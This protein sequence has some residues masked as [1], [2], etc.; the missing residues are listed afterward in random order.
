MRAIE[1]DAYGGID[2]LVLREAEEG[3]LRRGARVR[4]AWAALNPKDALVRKGKFRRLS[5]TRFPKRCGLDFAGEIADPGTTSFAK[6]DR[7]F[8][9]LGEWKCS[10]GTL[11][12]YVDVRENELARLPESV[13]FEDGAAVALAGLT[14]FQAL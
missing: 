2:R 9:M 12:E 6:G 3:R 14:A 13:A 11:A 10:R 1:Y 8:G 5:G 7:V 4:V